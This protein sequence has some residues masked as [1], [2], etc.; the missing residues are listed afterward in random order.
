MTVGS[1]Q[2][3]EEFIVKLFEKFH[4]CPKHKMRITPTNCTICGKNEHYAKELCH[5]CYRKESYKLNKEK[6]V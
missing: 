1:P 3:D 5:S 4:K 2:Y 6:V